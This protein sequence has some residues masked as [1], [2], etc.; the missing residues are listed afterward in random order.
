[1]L[2]AMSTQL[3][4]GPS[5]GPKDVNPFIDAAMSQVKLKPLLDFLFQNF[6][7]LH[8]HSLLCRKICWLVW[9]FTNCCLI[10]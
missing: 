7:I 10:I 5:P 8:T 2:V 3:L 1:M 4:S 6:Q 9:W